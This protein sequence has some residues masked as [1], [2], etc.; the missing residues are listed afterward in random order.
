MGGE[1][2]RLI[3]CHRDAVYNSLI[4]IN[5]IYQRSGKGG[6]GNYI[7]EIKYE[8]ER[9]REEGMAGRNSRFNDSSSLINLFL[10]IMT[11]HLS[12]V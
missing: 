7:R 8:R 10:V 1:Q 3:G 11:Q 6:G 5:V 4:K 2:T 12:S 9:E